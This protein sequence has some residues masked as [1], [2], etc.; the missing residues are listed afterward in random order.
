MVLVLALVILRTAV[1]V[2]PLAIG[3][4]SVLIVTHF[5]LAIVNLKQFSAHLAV[6]GHL[7]LSFWHDVGVSIPPVGLDVIPIPLGGPYRIWHYRCTISPI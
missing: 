3:D 7:W 5:G 1:H 4:A 2:V 6:H